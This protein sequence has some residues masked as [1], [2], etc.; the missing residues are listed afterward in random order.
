MNIFKKILAVLATLFLISIPNAK[1]YGIED[2]EKEITEAE[3]KFSMYQ[4]ELYL[5]N[6]DEFIVFIEQPWTEEFQ[7]AEKI[8]RE[9]HP[10]EYWN[11]VEAKSRLDTLR[12]VIYTATMNYISV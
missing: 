2:L 9:N 1:A 7:R 6:K 3:D 10:K 5:A 12:E 4:S 8:L 11:Y